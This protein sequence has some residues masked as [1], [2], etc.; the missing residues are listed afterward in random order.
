MGYAEIRIHFD[1][2]GKRPRSKDRKVITQRLIERDGAN[3]WICSYP[4]DLSLPRDHD[5]SATIDHRHPYSRGGSNRLNNL[6]LAHKCC[7]ERRRNPDI[8][9]DEQ[10]K[11]K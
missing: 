10:R 9:A 8:Q 11:E 5:E 2:F 6:R 4:I 3:C 1:G 7:N